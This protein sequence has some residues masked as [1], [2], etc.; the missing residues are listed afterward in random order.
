MFK[1]RQVKPGCKRRRDE[2]EEAVIEKKKA[3]AD[4][5]VPSRAVLIHDTK[6]AQHE[7][8]LTN[9]PK[10]IKVFT[11]TDLQPDVCKEF[12]K[13]GFCGYG[14]TCK[15]LHIRDELVQKVPIEKRWKVEKKPLQRETKAGECPI[16]KS[17]VQSP[18]ETHCGHVFC[19]ACCLGLFKKGTACFVCGADTHGA[20]QPVK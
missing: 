6:T 20:V 7:S 16:C 2:A 11:V 5:V 3:K 18:V 4:K 19:K 17:K 14:D 1:K 12:F 13:N 8:E 9:G 15:F 10:N